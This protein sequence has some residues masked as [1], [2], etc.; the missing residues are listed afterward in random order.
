MD[1]DVA[2]MLIRYGA[3]LTMVVFGIS[4]MLNPNKWI[5]Y[6]PESL[7]KISP[8][9]PQT[10]MRLHAIGNVLLG[11]W[12]ISGMYIEIALWANIIW[13]ISILP[14]AFIK[15]WTIGLRD[16]SIIMALIAALALL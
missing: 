14:F 2:I 7:R 6:I 8:I 3:A 15:E 10:T 4:Q 9:Q 5:D 13:W 16:V 11:L 1:T 12:L